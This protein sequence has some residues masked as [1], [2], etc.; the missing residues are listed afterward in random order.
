MFNTSSVP[1]RLRNS[2]IHQCLRIEQANRNLR[3]R[4]QIHYCYH[5]FRWVD[6]DDWDSHCQSHLFSIRSKRCGSIIHSHTL[7]RPAYCPFCLSDESLPASLRYDPWEREC[8]LWDHV[9]KHI[10]TSLWPRTC[11]HP[12][13]ATA[14]KTALSFRYHLHDDHGLCGNFSKPEEEITPEEPPGVNSP[15]LC[16]TVTRNQKRKRKASDEQAVPSWRFVQQ[17]DRAKVSLPRRNDADTGEQK[18]C[19]TVSPDVLSLGTT[20]GQRERHDLARPESRGDSPDL[21]L[22]SETQTGQDVFQH[23][24]PPTESGVPPVDDEQ[25]FQFIRLPSADTFYADEEQN[26][27]PRTTSP[28]GGSTNGQDWA[29]TSPLTVKPVCMAASAWSLA[30]PDDG[31]TT[32]NIQ[33]KDPTSHPGG[34]RIR[35][36]VGPPETKIRLRFHRPKTEK[37]GRRSHKRARRGATRS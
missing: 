26:P 8:E 32:H 13:C 20:L 14:F 30:S 15:G 17:S 37:E 21:S 34:P 35:L 5:C 11:P 4:S 23:H 2:H 18:T 33:H 28:T 29:T 7:I 24:S 9:V 19:Q 27:S 16:Q 22:K 10:D 12:L 6:R 3:I 31:S 25:L 36:R 1:K